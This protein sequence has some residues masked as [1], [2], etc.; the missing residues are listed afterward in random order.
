MRKLGFNEWQHGQRFVPY[1]AEGFWAKTTS[2]IKDWLSWCKFKSHQ[3]LPLYF[4]L[5]QMIFDLESH[6]KSLPGLRKPIL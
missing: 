1:L 2:S 6:A 4:L 5:C 3:K